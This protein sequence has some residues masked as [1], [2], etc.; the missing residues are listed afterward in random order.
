MTIE[1]FK[2]TI[3]D[4]YFMIAETTNQVYEFIWHGDKSDLAHI[5]HHT[6]YRTRR[7][8]EGIIRQ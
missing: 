6:L 3:G 7:E 4:T 1:R 8:A 2:P 5:Q